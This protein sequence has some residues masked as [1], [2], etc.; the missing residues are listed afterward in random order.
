M[1]I[2]SLK[3]RHLGLGI[4]PIGREAGYHFTGCCRHWLIFKTHAG[5]VLR[6]SGRSGSAMASPD[7]VAV[8]FRG[9]GKPSRVT[10]LATLSF[11]RT[12][13]WPDQWGRIAYT[14]LPFAV[15][16]ASMVARPDAELSISSVTS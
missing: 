6:F 4:S 8:N 12:K 7:P 2:A 15:K 5:W 16:N 9:V 11:C 14:S 10:D 13:L 1:Q 3:S